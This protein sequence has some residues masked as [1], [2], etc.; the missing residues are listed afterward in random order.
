MP[1]HLYHYTNLETLKLILHYKTFRLSS[2]NRMDDLEEGETEDFQKLGRFIYISSWTDNTA[3]SLLLWGYSRGNDGVRIRMKSN[4]FKTMP[5][6]GNV[7]I[8]GHNVQ[9]D[10]NY[11]IGILD[12]MKNK[13]VVFF[14]PR[15]ELVRVTYTDLNRLLKPTVFKK[16]PNNGGFEIQTKDLGIFKRVEWQDQREWRYRLSSIPLNINEVSM[17]N[18]PHMYDAVIEKIKTREELDFIDLP[19]REDAF[20]DLEIL[21]GPQMSPEGKE[22]LKIVLQQYAPNAIVR[23]SRMRIRV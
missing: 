8:H 7:N 17:C 20:D 9:V 11:H 13:D 12:L 22:E 2:L 3:E 21:C 16:Y 6:N 18:N 1:E 5:V 10:D 4:I 19:L 23:D 15:A 14:P